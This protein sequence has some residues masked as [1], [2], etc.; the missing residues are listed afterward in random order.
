M[1]RMHR[2]QIVPHRKR[3]VRNGSLHVKRLKPALHTDSPTLIPSS[4]GPMYL[5]I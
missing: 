5:K 3:N 1:I 4:A 2:K